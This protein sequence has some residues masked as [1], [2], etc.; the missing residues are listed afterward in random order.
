M[1]KDT[2]TVVHWMDIENAIY[3]STFDFYGQ[4]NEDINKVIEDVRVIAHLWVEPD[5]D[6]PQVMGYKTNP[7][8]ELHDWDIEAIIQFFE[9]EVDNV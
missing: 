9:E 3:T 1:T 5:V 7:E 4:G 8:M 6:E 2:D